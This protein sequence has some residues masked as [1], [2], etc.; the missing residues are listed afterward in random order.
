MRI[1]SN[2]L[3]DQ[4]QLQLQ[5]LGQDQ[6]RY[7]QQIAS[8][9]RLQSLSEDPSAANRLMDYSSRKRMVQQYDNNAEMAN[10]ASVLNGMHLSQLKNMSNRAYNVA[11]GAA[12]QNPAERSLSSEQINGI[13]ETSLSLVNSRHN[14][15]NLYG[16]SEFTTT[17]FAVTRD[18][19]GKIT[20]VTYNGTAGSAPSIQIGEQLSV[21]PLNNG[22]KNSQ[23]AA[24]LN[25]LVGL[26]DAISAGDVTQTNTFQNGVADNEDQLL[27]M[28]ADN[29]S[30]QYQIQIARESNSARF[31]QLVDLHDQDA[32][33]NMANTMLA[34]KQTQISYEAALQVAGSMNQSSL[35]DYL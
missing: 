29:A 18:A 19:G 17:P 4:L 9:Q 24:F 11:V 13:L 25:N 34:L 6:S 26:R 35:L 27:L 1:T 21:S 12:S 32:G 5:R 23:L 33:I 16:G 3:T 14:G 30:A 10:Q 7:T 8:G 20:G 22:A 2:T 28:E 31:N 15:D